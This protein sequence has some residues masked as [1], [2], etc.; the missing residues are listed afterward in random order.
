MQT[1]VDRRVFERTDFGSFGWL[2]EGPLTPSYE[3][4][5]FASTD[6]QLRSSFRAKDRASIDPRLTDFGDFAWIFKV[7]E[8]A[9]D[10]SFF[11]AIEALSRSFRSKDNAKLNLRLTDF[12]SFGWIKEGPITPLY[13]NSFFAA[14]DALLR[15]SFRSKEKS[16]L[17]SRLTDFGSFG[18]I[19]K[20]AENLVEPAVAAG[21]TY[22]I[23]YRRRRRS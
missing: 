4:A 15:S 11:T 9:F 23:N 21:A 14:I 22:I 6:A 20:V 2:K 3:V 1:R 18:W 10:V 8:A 12:D 16:R 17:D 7:I 13:D 19:A 5:F